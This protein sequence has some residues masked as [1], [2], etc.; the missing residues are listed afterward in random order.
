MYS[1]IECKINM[2]F[3]IRVTYICIYGK[4]IDLDFM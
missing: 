1:F 3:E 4:Q 2:G